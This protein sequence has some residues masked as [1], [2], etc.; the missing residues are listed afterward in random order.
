MNESF[1]E[2]DEE[3]KRNSLRSNKSKQIKIKKRINELEIKEIES[4]NFSPLSSKSKDIKLFFNKN[5]QDNNTN[6]V[7]FI[8]KKI[9]DDKKRIKLLFNENKENKE[10]INNK[11]NINIKSYKKILKM[12]FYDKNAINNKKTNLTKDKYESLI[13][14]LI[15]NII[16]YKVKNKNKNNL[17]INNNDIDIFFIFF[18][19]IK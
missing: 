15:N 14:K 8:Y 18:I 5:I 13:H 1:E 4:I 17:I 3:N 2:Q 16:I 6:D 19:F 11:Y 7:F 10:N 12:A 9:I